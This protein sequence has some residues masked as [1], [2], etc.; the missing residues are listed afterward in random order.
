M[1][2]IQGWGWEW[3]EKTHLD[4]LELKT[5][6]KG[7]TTLFELL[8]ATA[9]TPDKKVQT[10]EFMDAV[11]NVKTGK[12][13]LRTLN[14]DVQTFFPVSDVSDPA[15]RT[16]WKYRGVTRIFGEAGLAHSAIGSFSS[17]PLHH[18]A[19]LIYAFIPYYPKIEAKSKFLTDYQVGME[20]V[21][22][23]AERDWPVNNEMAILEGSKREWFV[24]VEGTVKSIGPNYTLIDCGKPLFIESKKFLGLEEGNGI[25]AEGA[26]YAYFDP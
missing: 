26:L 11:K 15:V 24:K 21:P 14:R 1:T 25:R 6:L 9:N 10:G 17:H 4:Q 12:V 16:P 8:T 19:P 22:Q 20:L 23:K 18:K 13:I 3:V 2:D 7:N 5:G